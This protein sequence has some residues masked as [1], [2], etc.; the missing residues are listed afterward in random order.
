MLFRSAPRRSHPRPQKLRILANFIGW[1][2]HTLT[3]FLAIAVVLDLPGFI[4]A[5][6]LDQRLADDMKH[7]LGNN[8]AKLAHMQGYILVYIGAFL[9]TMFLMIGR[10]SQGILHMLRPI[11]AA[12]CFLI[13]MVMLDHGL[14]H[15]TPIKA[16]DSAPVADARTANPTPTQVNDA[17]V[18]YLDAAQ[19]K[20]SIVS[21]FLALTGLA[22][23]LW[24]A[25]QPKL[26][27]NID[28]EEGAP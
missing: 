5:G 27:Q 14:G 2:F 20:L 7:S 16:P 18:Q 19:A 12:A 21:L 25:R 1:A 23:L 8:W 17:I 24:P 3:F 15:W 6:L 22:L 28:R 9:A 26:E 4:S 11:F 10:R 13:A